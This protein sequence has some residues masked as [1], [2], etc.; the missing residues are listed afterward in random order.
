MALAADL[1]RENQRTKVM[2]V[3]GMSIGLSFALALVLGPVLNAW[4]GVPGIFW[5]TALFAVL[6]IFLVRFVVPTP[7]VSRTHRDAEAVA[8]LFGRVL[9]DRQ[10]LRLDLGIL[11][12]HTLMT[13]LFLVVPLVLEDQVGLSVENH[14]KLYLP[15][16]V[17]SILAMLPFIVVAERHGR[18]K[19]VFLGAILTL[20][21]A[22]VG[23]AWFGTGV[24][25]LATWLLVFFAAFNL[26]EATLP[27]LISRMAPAGLKGTA[28]GVYS[29]SQFF[30]AFLGGLLGG[31]M[32]KLFGVQGVFLFCALLTVFWFAAA[33]GMR[34]PGALRSRL[35]SVGQMSEDEAR[36]LAPR[37]ARVPGVDEVVVI[38]NEGVAYLKVD[39]K[40]LDVTEL[41]K[42][43]VADA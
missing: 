17:G 22:E 1:T 35:L 20:G 28:M 30:G 6:G 31:W 34:N 18:T 24:V 13:A 5:L 7:V 9:G 29:T 16:L 4:F 23:F 3:I 2:A 36:S 37:L 8:G 40:T 26:L 43:S 42:F 19:A 12:L 25:A 27:S 41:N 21:V 10:L 33:A 39:P 14:W 15:V 11:L 38:A 32:Q